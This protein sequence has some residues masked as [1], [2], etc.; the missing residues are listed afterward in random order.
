MKIAFNEAV[1]RENSDTAKN[2]EYC[3]TVG[4]DYIELRT[5]VLK[6]F[7]AAGG[8]LEYIKD[9]FAKSRIKP[10]A[11]N[12]L[13][14]YQDLFGPNDDPEK[15]K[16]LMEQ[17]HSD[18][19]AI[20]A[21]G[22]RDYVIVPPLDQI[23][24]TVPYSGNM[25]TMFDDCVRILKRLGEMAA[26]QGIRLAFEPVGAPKSGVRTVEFAYDIVKAVD[27]DNVGLTIDAAN[28]YIYGGEKPFACIEKLPEEKIF[29]A[30]IMDYDDIPPEQYT[31]D[32][33]C[34]CGKGA[35]PVGEFLA[36][37]KKVGYD[38]EVSVEVF[39]PEYW[40]MEPEAAI[41]EAYDTTKKALAD[42]GCL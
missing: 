13:Y 20:K 11:F 19:E 41:K 28:L 33:R 24:F 36:A 2:L 15:Q 35:L 17:F 32:N 23:G 34:F 10:S 39:R 25:D 3:E 37:L 21:I 40:A 8:T 4:F 16:A 5:E 29:I 6:K 18:C 27:M 9:F 42:A 31:A 22:G 38:R 7:K 30:H 12:A 26:E 14:I 1:T